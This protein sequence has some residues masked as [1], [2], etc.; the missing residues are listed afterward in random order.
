MARRLTLQTDD[1]ET[2]AA[3]GWITGV[4]DGEATVTDH[5]VEDGSTISDHVQAQPVQITLEIRQ[6]E[7]PLEGADGPTGEER[8][9]QALRFLEDARQAGELL[10]VDL[11]RVGVY[12]NMVVASRSMEIDQRKEGRFEVVLRQIEIAEVSIVSVPI[13]AV[14]PPSRAGQQDEED[15]GRQSTDEQEESSIGAEIEG[16]FD[17]FTPD[18]DS[19]SALQQGVNAAFN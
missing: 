5:P 4:V 9:Q 18:E 12:E 1:G 16:L 10:T 15:L 6:T 8:V 17:R 11:P 14:E 13:E 7:T 2:L 19:E 3:D